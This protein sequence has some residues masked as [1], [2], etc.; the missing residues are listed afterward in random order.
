M[1]PWVFVPLWRNNLKALNE[2]E[3][4]MSSDDKD[5]LSYSLIEGLRNRR[6]RRFALGMKTDGPLAFESKHQPVSLTEEEEALLVFAGCGINGYAL[7]DLVIDPEGGGSIMTHL[8]GRTVASGD[9]AQAVAM[10][11]VNDEGA[12]YVKRPQNLTRDEIADVIRMVRQGNLTNFY[13]QYRV[14]IKDGRVAPPIEPMFNLVCNKWSVYKPGTT[15]FIPINDISFI[16]INGLLNILGLVTGAYILDER[17][18]FRSAGLEQFARSKG[19]HLNDDLK[20]SDILTILVAEIGTAEL[21]AIEQGM[22][23]QNMALMAEAI[24][25]GGFPN[26]AEH[27][28]G[29]FQ[30]LGFRMGEM[31]CA[32]YFGKGHFLDIAMHALKRDLPVPY[33]L[34]LECDGKILLKGYCPPYFK[35]MRDAVEAL[36]DLKF[37]AEGIFRGRA[38]AS[39]WRD[40]EAI[41]AATPPL[42]KQVVEATVSY[43]EY[44]YETYGRFP[45]YVAPFRTV[46]GYQAGHLDINFYD[47]YYQP[48]VLSET[49]RQHM[50]RW[51]EE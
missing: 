8:T 26:F 13:K 23:Y 20:S 47:R 45:A 4:D 41:V 22:M 15:Y 3:F 1:R 11:V 50:K 10:I 28:F 7:S 30:A 9:G 27:E 34:G 31:G 35:S 19:G 42:P 40:P 16:Y 21:V 46:L 29:W 32:E 12:Y 33:P 36:V 5:V 49:H 51:H 48:E 14:K 2:T 25:I 24:G 38:T 17:H 43:C 6:S 39:A 44:I 18:H 37:G